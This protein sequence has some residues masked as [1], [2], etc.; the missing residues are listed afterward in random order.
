MFIVKKKNNLTIVV[1]CKNI[2]W[3]SNTK[4]FYIFLKLVNICVLMTYR[5]LISLQTHY[6]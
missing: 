4:F 6:N 1:L 3:P 2:N 5:V